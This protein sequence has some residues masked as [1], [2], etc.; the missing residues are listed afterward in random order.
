MD[1]AERQALTSSWAK[2]MWS[3]VN[4]LVAQQIQNTEIAATLTRLDLA[5]LFALLDLAQNEADPETTIDLT[6][7]L[8]GLMEQTGKP[9][10][11]QRIGQ[12]RNAAVEALGDTWN[13]AHFQATR[14]VINQLQASGLLREAFEKA[15]K[16]H[17]RA[18]EVGEQAYPGADYDLA[19]A[20][21]L[22]ARILNIVGNS[23]QALTLVDEARQRFE[24]IAAQRPGGGAE[25]MVSACFSEKGECL[26]HLGQLD[27]AVAAY[28]ESIR[29]DKELGDIRGIAVGKGQIGS[30]R[31]DQGRY[32]EALRAH[33]EAR[34]RFTQLDEPE[35]IAGSWNQTGVVYQDAGELEAAEDA[36][37]KS[38]A[39]E[40]QLGNVVGQARTLNQ[41][42]TLYNEL[43]KLE[44]AVAFYQQA[45]NKSIEIGDILN[46]GRQ[47]QNLA[48]TLQKLKR[49]DEARQ[50][51]L[52]AIGCKSKFG[53][54]SRIWMTWAILAE[55]EKKTAN[56]AASA[57]AKRK[58]I[59]SYLVYRRDGGENH[60]G[61]GRISL[62]VTESLFAGEMNTAESLLQQLAA[63]PHSIGSLGAYI[64]ALRAIVAGSRDRTLA[65][66]E[67]LDF[68][69]AAEIILL[70]EKLESAAG[71]N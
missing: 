32:S 69:M 19:S 23:E 65:D 54:A 27:E 48:H 25:K 22:L 6:T 1:A 9:R 7:S 60:D 13:H 38:L 18:K 14:T 71:Q 17:Q 61:D 49:L 20:C 15:Y 11:V 58:A 46:E 47:R 70:I 66:A 67:D 39:I 40:V 41:L 26:W 56:P 10:L 24:A 36:Y 5:N 30:I 21:W 34:D 29:R 51:I 31:N 63:D 4:F 35:A 42:G 3:Y 50:E 45:V 57:D 33:A 12:V 2:N 59:A 8:Y 55:I 64:R 44:E 62:A 37:R 52:R 28:E 68:G 43:G 53:H 16:L